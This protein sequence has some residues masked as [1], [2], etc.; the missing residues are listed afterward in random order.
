MYGMIHKAIKDMVST[1]HGADVWKTI[2]TDAGAEDDDFLSLRS[3]DDEVCYRLVGS[4]AK[5]LDVP[6]AQ[7]L[8]QFGRFWVLTTAAQNY[9]PMLR[10]FGNETIQLLEHLN[11]MHERISST[12]VGYRPPRFNIERIG[13]RECRLHYF[14]IREGLTPFVNGLLE[15]LGEY[16]DEDIKIHSIQPREISS[17]EHTEYHLTTKPRKAS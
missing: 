9:G 10:S 11:Q 17:G 3:Y 5:I 7:C 12:F 16:F 2:A 1:T 8:E 13:D 6:A 4:T 14:S 15:G